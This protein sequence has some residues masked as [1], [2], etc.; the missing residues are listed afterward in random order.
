MWRQWIPFWKAGLSPYGGDVDLLFIGLL[1]A[2]SLVLGLLFVLLALFC[3]YF[4]RDPE[5]EI[6]TGPVAVAPA[7]GRV[8]AIKPE[9]ALNRLSLGHPAAL[10]W[11][12]VGQCALD[13]GC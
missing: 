6:P 7:D 11:C 13:F 4:F 2:S 12:C 9:G 1:F 8:V 3:L 10:F 5:R